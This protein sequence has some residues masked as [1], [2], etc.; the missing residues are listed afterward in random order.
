MKSYKSLK[1]L[2]YKLMSAKCGNSKF[3]VLTWKPKNTRLHG[4]NKLLEALI[5]KECKSGYYKGTYTTMFI[6]VVFINNGILFN[7]KEE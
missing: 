1:Y 7:H 3:Q 4:P 2:P 5:T 6:A